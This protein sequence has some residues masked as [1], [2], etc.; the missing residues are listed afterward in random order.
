VLLGVPL[1]TGS[2]TKPK[3]NFMKKRTSFY[4]KQ[5]V[6]F[7]FFLALLWLPFNALNAQWTEEKKIL[8]QVP[9]TPFQINDS[10]FAGST[11]A[12]DGDYALVGVPFSDVKGSNSGMALLYHYDGS[13]WVEEK[14]LIPNDE[15]QVNRF[16]E[17]VSIS[18]DI[19]IVSASFDDQNGNSRG[20][21]HI[22]AR[23]KGG[24]GNWGLVKKLTIGDSVSSS[25]SFVRSVSISG[26]MAIVGVLKGNNGTVSSSAQI[27]SRNQGGQE[28]WGLVSELVAPDGVGGDQFGLSLAISGD[29]AMVG[30]T[31]DDDKGNESGS[32]YVFTQDKSGLGNWGLVRKLV[33]FDGREDHQFGF[34]ISISGDIA[35]IGAVGDD[36]N[37][38]R[39]GSAYTFIR[40]K[41]GQENWGFESKLVAPDGAA[42]RYFGH[43]VSVSGGLAMVGAPLV[44]GRR[45][46]GSA[47]IFARN[48]GEWN[49]L[50]KLV[51]PDG[52]IDDRFGHSVSISGDRSLVGSPFDDEN[53]RHSGSAYIFINDGDLGGW[54]FSRKL[55]A[56]D[57][58]VGDRFGWPV[59]ISGDIAL[60]G[61]N[62]DDE[63]GNDSGS[64]YIFARNEGGIGNW[65]VVKKLVSPENSSNS[66]GWSVSVSDNVAVVGEIDEMVYVFVR[67]EGG[68]DNWGIKKQ[69][70]SPEGG[71][72]DSF[73]QSVSILDD[74]IIVGAP[75]NDENGSGSGA[76]YIFVRD[77]GGQGNWGFERKLV[78][79]DGTAYDGFGRSVSISKGVIIVGASGDD[80]N[81][82]LSGSA[83]VFAQDGN[84]W[85]FVKKLVPQDGAAFN[86]FGR[87]VSISHDV[88]LVGSVGGETRGRNGS[89]Y[90]FAR[91]TGGS[92]N[93]GLVSKLV[94]PESAVGERFGE[95]VSIS[96]DL[97]I[98]GSFGD[99]DKGGERGSVYIFNR[100][101][102]GLNNWGL[103]ERIVATDGSIFNNFGRS[104][105]IA[106][107][108]ILVG[109][110]GDEQNGYNSGA[111][112]I[113]SN[114]A[115]D[116]TISIT[117]FNL[118]NAD[119]NELIRELYD[120]EVIDVKNL[121]TM[122]LAIEAVA[123]DDTE[124]VRLALS[125]AMVSGR[126]EN[127][128]PYA[129]FGDIG[130]NYNGKGFALGDYYI[131]ATPYTGKKLGGDRGNALT[132]GF[133]FAD[134][135]PKELSVIGF[136]LIDADKNE[137]IRGIR[138]GDMID[139]KDLPTMNLNIEAV[140]TDDVQ[141]VRLALSG[142][143]ISERTE[144]VAPYALFGDK[145]GNFNGRGFDLGDYGIV[146]TPYSEDRLSGTQGNDMAIGFTLIETSTFQ[147]LKTMSI[148]PNPANTEVTLGFDAPVAVNEI[149]VFDMSGRL[150]KRFDAK[151][152]KDRDNYPAN[153][154]GIPAGRYIILAKDDK[155]LD[156]SQHMIIEE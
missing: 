6:S 151:E 140:T 120:G 128:A 12:I 112:Y 124:S 154:L 98:V 38:F 46:S 102:G 28:N 114:T 148:Y 111:A 89:A 116:S 99:E 58:T 25:L 14:A 56:S 73:G 80:E 4:G 63:K 49:F 42:V 129:L 13:D 44:S 156:Y 37:G 79:P 119:S 50:N 57:G 40:N 41:G 8:A 153:V 16:G 19:A 81:G 109:A 101:R 27:F 9:D 54:N 107:G 5:K 70:V 36:D 10:D 64:A 123:T 60:V 23:D 145:G 83:Y 33:A 21:A 32:V 92:N 52:V 135:P 143:M 142:S 30:A 39:G 103:S 136:N 150:V 3:I 115:A 84:S 29:V 90:I 82:R 78:A 138:D 139:V 144:N 26:D 85:G 62:G 132:I 68:E 66:F 121:P 125:G 137:P 131:T 110:S 51:P 146:A 117:G 11:V 7:L 97:A 141:S 45:G 53:G 1:K 31:G 18:G 105:S 20:S 24:L 22:F 127:V 59:S 122:N 34:S 74:T 61:A 133:T 48:E 126:I 100:N 134:V 2:I 87:S 15:F 69:L 43:S 86:H 76:V 108:L 118:I 72:F 67:N 17:S 96:E 93:W 104:V 113:F 65:G 35:L 95:S 94:A 106:D 149:L 152:T 88:A 77:K 155:G 55:L 91:N 130:G 47:Y 75:G 147:P 71:E